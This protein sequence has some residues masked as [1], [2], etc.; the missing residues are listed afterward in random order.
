MSPYVV[1][2]NSRPQENEVLW[3][4]VRTWSPG[5]R[6]SVPK[7]GPLSYRTHAL[8]EELR[9]IVHE[10]VASEAAGANTQRICDELAA[11]AIYATYWPT[12]ATRCVL[13]INHS[14]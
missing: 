13:S 2:V 10:I 7:H 14:P 11:K 3:P 1:A 4:S 6:C 5:S 12:I 9:I 8:Y